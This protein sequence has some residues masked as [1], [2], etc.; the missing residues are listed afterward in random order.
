M[1]TA[2]QERSVWVSPLKWDGKSWSYSWGSFQEL[3]WAHRREANRAQAFAGRASLLQ[4]LLQQN[5][6]VI[7][8]GDDTSVL[9]YRRV[10]SLDCIVVDSYP[11]IAAPVAN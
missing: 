4:R 8:L 7:A 5:D 6:K 9:I 2:E 1:I 10:E 11:P 3:D